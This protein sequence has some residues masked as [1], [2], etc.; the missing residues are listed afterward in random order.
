MNDLPVVIVGAGPG[1]AVC[2]AALHKM[3][4]DVLV[5]E[6][7]TFPRF[8]IGESLLPVTLVHL[9]EVGLL[10]A[11]F[12]AG[13][14]K[15]FGA[16]FS[17]ETSSS[18]VDF[19]KCWNMQ[20][21]HAFNLQR[22]QFDHVL[23]QQV[24]A[25]GVPIRWNTRIESAEFDGTKWVVDV[26][27]PE[28]PEQVFASF[29][30]D[31][32]GGAII[33]KAKQTEDTRPVFSAIFSH[34]RDPNRPGGFEE[35]ATWVLSNDTVTW[36]WVIPFSDGT[37]SVGFVG[38]DAEV[39]AAAESDDA[40]FDFLMN[41]YRSSRE[42]FPV[43]EHVRIKP[44]LISNFR[45]KFVKPSGA[46]YC[47]IGNSL[48]FL[49][50]IFSSGVA[51]ATESGL[52]AARAIDAMR[53]DPQFDWISGYDEPLSRGLHVFSDC[54]EAWYDGV[55]PALIHSRDSTNTYRAQLEERIVALLAGG[56]WDETNSLTKDTA[57]NLKFLSKR[58]ADTVP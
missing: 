1:G 56:V 37:A 19:S 3:G 33:H 45:R 13:F 5:L 6:R 4:I 34:V 29:I 9:K 23:A 18:R 8:T 40:R 53:A 55:L 43:V 52:R 36:A 50:P 39:R 30:V 38:P 57:W 15:K 17:N 16:V 12:A 47:L 31:S 20:A 24:E 44:R 21:P 25:L 27:G 7:A 2:A 35:G 14:Q 22:D 48:G 32:S 41:A 10:D 11:V 54:V 46:G 49:D 42:R 26:L 28:G 51:I 58:L